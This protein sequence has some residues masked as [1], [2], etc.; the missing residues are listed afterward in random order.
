MIRERAIGDTVLQRAREYPAVAIMGPR[1]S[2]KTTLARE[3]FK[4][5]PYVSLE[6]SDTRRFA[7]DDPRG[8]LAEYPDGA[9]LDEVQ[10]CPG[11]FSYLQGVIDDSP[12]KGRFILTGSQQFHLHSRI[13]QSLAGRISMLELLPFSLAEVYGSKPP[14]LDEVLYRGFYPPVH[15][16]GVIPSVWY[17]DYVNTYIERDV[18]ELLRVQDL[19]LYRRFVRLCAERIGCLVNLSGLARDVGVRHNTVRSWLSVLEASYII[20][21]LRP[22]HGSLTKRQT[23]MPKLYFYDTGLAAAIL[24]L[25]EPSQMQARPTGGLLFENWVIAELIKAAYNKGVRPN[26]YFWRD[27]SKREVD[28]VIEG[29]TECTAVEIKA[30]LTLG[31]DKFKGL[32]YWREHRGGNSWLVYGGDETWRRKGTRV[33]G[34]RRLA[35]L[36]AVI[37][38]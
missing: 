17:G 30:G 29:G 33:I 3:L 21:L 23:K 10:R 5:K 38:G 13:A 28:L 8:F 9:V 35:E 16:G 4:D 7:H 34:W 2:G 19:A 14:S 18:R 6:A 31:A 37:P 11:L 36:E 27:H 12:G 25:T 26:F 1:Q 32:D 15:S 24:S 22:Y 20:F